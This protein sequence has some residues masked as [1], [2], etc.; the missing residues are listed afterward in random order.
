MVQDDVDVAND[1]EFWEWLKNRNKDQNT[2]N[3]TQPVLYIYDDFTPPN[4]S[5]NEEQDKNTIISYDDI[6][7]YQCE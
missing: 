6:T 2:N 4:L 1:P 3:E 7:V 5:E